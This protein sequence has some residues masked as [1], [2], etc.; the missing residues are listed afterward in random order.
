MQPAF[1]L[2]VPSDPAH[3][4]RIGTKVVVLPNL[5]RASAFQE[6]LR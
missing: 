4:A 5:T 3:R 6:S 1:R 2:Q